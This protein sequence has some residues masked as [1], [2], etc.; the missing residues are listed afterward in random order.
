MRLRI[1]P[2]SGRKGRGVPGVPTPVDRDDGRCGVASSSIDMQGAPPLPRSI[3]FV[4]ALQ[5]AS[6]PFL[7]EHIDVEQPGHG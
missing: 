6:S 7:A 4:A 1:S 3:I 5:A 2:T